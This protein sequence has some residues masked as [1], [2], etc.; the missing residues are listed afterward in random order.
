MALLIAGDWHRI[1]ILEKRLEKTS[2]RVMLKKSNLSSVFQILEE[3]ASASI[4][5]DVMRPEP[6]VKEIDHGKSQTERR[7]T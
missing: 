5:G 4:G 3:S 7:K 2:P 6:P 1:E